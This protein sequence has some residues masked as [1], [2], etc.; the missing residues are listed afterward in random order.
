MKTK[1]AERMVVSTQTGEQRFSN[2]RNGSTSQ[3]VE[4]V[5][6]TEGRVLTPVTYYPITMQKQFD[7]NKKAVHGQPYVDFWNE[8]LT[9]PSAWA[10]ALQRGPLSAD[11][12]LTPSV[13]DV[14]KI[15]DPSFAFPD[16]G[17][18]LLEGPC[19][20]S[21]ARI[22]M[23]GVTTDMFKWWFLWHPVEKE[24]YM[25]WFPHAHIDNYVVDPERLTDKTLTYE[26]RLY[27]N[28]NHVEEFIGPSSLKIIIHFT[29]PVEL[30]F[31]PEVLHNA[32]ITASASGPISVADAP[33]T[34][35][36]FMLHLAR[37]TERGMEL[38]SRYWIGAHPEFKRFQGGADAPALLKTMGMDS[39]SLEALAYEMSVHDMTEF[40]QLAVMLPELYRR[41]RD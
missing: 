41:F 21:Q 26:Q 32:G 1:E 12:T 36:M 6:A 22:E 33:D 18:A 38:F 10:K 3:A 8:D 17:H 20:Y 27:G 7:L 4:R 31:R 16:A 24:R 11:Q 13:E 40:N 14:N 35:F 29:D 5:G 30:G 15:F 9:V 25:L 2:S 28:P 19:A 23:P 34:T 39:G 37:D